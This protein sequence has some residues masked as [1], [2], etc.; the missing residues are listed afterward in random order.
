MCCCLDALSGYCLRNCGLDTLSPPPKKRKKEF[1]RFKE[2]VLEFSGEKELWIK[3]S[4]PLLKEH[5]DTKNNNLYSEFIRKLGVNENS[6]LMKDY[7]VDMAMALLEE[8]AKDYVETPFSNSMRDNILRYEYIKL[9]WDKYRCFAV[10]EYRSFP[11]K[12]PNIFNQNSKPYY[13]HET[14]LFGRGG[15]KRVKIDFSHQFIFNTLRQC[16]FNF[17]RYV[18]QH[19][20]IMK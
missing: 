16:L 6:Y 17:E 15:G 8:K 19:G 5:F 10:H 14:P 13:N 2:F 11:E 12:A 20:I 4:L 3:I 9:L 18:D 1:Y 7:D